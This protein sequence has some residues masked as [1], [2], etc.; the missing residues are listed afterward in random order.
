MGDSVIS[1]EMYQLQH[2]IGANGIGSICVLNDTEIS[3]VAS[4][5]VVIHDVST[6]SQRFIDTRANVAC[7]AINH[8]LTLLAVAEEGLDEVQIYD[9][10]TLRSK[11][12]LATNSNTTHISFSKD[13]SVVLTLTQSPAYAMTLWKM[14]KKNADIAASLDLSAVMGGEV[15]RADISSMN[16]NL[17]SVL[18]SRDVKTF[19][20]STRMN[21]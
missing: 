10:S 8:S 12:K 2:V 19:R 20:P 3:Y 13:S 15:L 11:I 17:V 1:S 7:M 21:F 6:N 9:V 16:P 18:G 4:K 14:N 5:R